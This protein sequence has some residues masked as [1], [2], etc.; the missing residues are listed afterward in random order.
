MWLAKE[1]RSTCGDDPARVDAG[2]QRHLLQQQREAL[3]RHRPA[4]LAAGEQPAG[5]VRR[6]G[7]HQRRRRA[8]AAS[9]SGTTRSRP[10]LP[11]T[12]SSAASPAS[13]ARGRAS[14]SETRRPV[15][16]RISSAAAASSPAG[17]GRARGRGEQRVDL[18]LGEVFRQA[19]RQARRDRAAR[20][21]IVGAHA[22]AQQEAVEL[23]QRRQPPRRGARRRRRPRQLRA[24]VGAQVSARR[25][26]PAP[27]RARAAKAG[28]IGQVGGVGRQRVAR[29]ARA[30]PP[31]SP[32]TPRCGG[33]SHRRP[34]R[35]GRGCREAVVRQHLSGSWLRHAARRRE[36]AEC[37]ERAAGSTTGMR[38]APARRA[39]ATISPAP[40]RP[41][42]AASLPAA[43]AGILARARLC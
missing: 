16:Y 6:P 33:P 2:R 26:R 42:T 10:P 11:R 5:R 22:L 30:R 9:D 43:A 28:E 31:A 21:G 23:A 39:I 38:R 27:R 36:C 8:R 13:A 37:A 35:A 14:S 1:W 12:S 24:H 41:G 29:R 17:A 20:V 15:A 7:R 32:G 34:P 3:P 19:A 25:P 40:A 18:R 4:R